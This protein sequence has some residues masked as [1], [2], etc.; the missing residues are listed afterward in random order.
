MSSEPSPT[1]VDE[2]YKLNFQKAI[3]LQNSGY[4]LEA[5]ELYRSIIETTPTIGAVSNLGITLREQ[6]KFEEA[7][8]FL[9]RAAASAPQN[10]NHIYNLAN[11]LASVGNIEQSEK[12]FRTALRIDPKHQLAALN[13]G[14]LLLSIGK[15]RDGFEFYEN[16]IGLQDQGNSTP[17]KSATRWMGEPL[18]GK[19]ILVQLEQGLGDQIMLSRFCRNLKALGCSHVSLACSPSLA[20]IFSPL[21]DSIIPVDGPTEIPTHDYWVYSGSLPHLL[22]IDLNI[23]NSE[24]Y[25]KAPDLYRQKWR[26][27]AKAGINIGLVTR[28]NPRHKSDRYRSIFE[29]S[30]INSIINSGFNIINLDSPRGNFADTAAII[31]QLD[32]IISVD[33]SIVH[34]SGAMG[35]PCWMMC[36]LAGVDWRW[37]RSG[38]NTPWYSS[39][40]I[41]RQTRLNQWSEVADRICHDLYNIYGNR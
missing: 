7:L 1:Q 23:L 28:G 5:E 36:S 26:G 22:Q 15:Y 6:G 34:L 2:N 31:E 13:L 30:S 29:T 4:F 12:A 37:M 20:P 27:F 25:I 9:V 35:L 40:K 18:K 24:A 14:H 21:A 3:D 11:G 33:T 19:S 17:P 38:S 8:P 41:Y 16:R 32:L 10:A 39:V